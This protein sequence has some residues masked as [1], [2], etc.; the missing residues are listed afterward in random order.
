MPQSDQFS[1]VWR[2]WYSY[3]SSGRAGQEFENEHYVRAHY[4]GRQVVFETVPGSKSYV[5]IRMT[6]QDG[7][8]TGSWQEETEADGYYKGAVYYGSIQMVT[9]DDNKEL[10]GKWVGFG[11]EMDINTGPWTLTYVGEEVPET[12]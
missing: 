1:G 5:I 4:D 7:V 6:V 10:R 9:G 8:A 2:S 12:A 3:P 11:R